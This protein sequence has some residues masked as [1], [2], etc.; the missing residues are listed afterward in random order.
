MTPRERR[1]A[2]ARAALQRQAEL[3]RAVEHSIALERAG[4]YLEAE[5][6]VAKFGLRDLVERDQL[7]TLRHRL[8]AQR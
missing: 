4:R 7:Y 3:Y 8:R 5:A 2:R 1:H 6:A